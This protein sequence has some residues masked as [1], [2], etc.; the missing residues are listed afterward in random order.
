[1]VNDCYQNNQI[2]SYL[3]GSL[4]TKIEIRMDIK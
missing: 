4:T 3:Q 2:Y 1:M